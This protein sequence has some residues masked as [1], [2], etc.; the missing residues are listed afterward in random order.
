MTIAI[1]LAGLG[2]I[3]L[4]AHLPALQ[5]NPHVR[6]AGLVDPDPARRAVA[7]ELRVAPVHAELSAV[8]GDPDVRAVVLAT[9]PWVTTELVL[10]VTATGRPVLAEKPVATSVT[11]AQV[12]AG[13]SAERRRL[14]QVGLTYRHDPALELLRER[15]TTGV[16]GDPLLVRAHVYDERRDRADTAHADRIERTLEHGM[17]VLHEGAHVFDW[18]RYLL[19]SAPLLVGDAWSVRTRADLPAANLCGARLVYPQGTVALVEFGWLTDAQP[20]CELSFLG[21]RG[22]ALLDGTSFRVELHTAGGVEQV[23]FQPDRTTRCF[24]RQLERFVELVTGRRSAPEPDLADGIAA[25]ELSERI[26]ELARKE[27]A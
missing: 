21:D 6:I 18:L 26:G 10:A 17:P 24:D 8:L 16:L 5:R 4:H 20:R 25:L 7:E 3:G 11:A 1:A 19:G 27:P 9:P 2:D 12:L 13:L 22:H 14:V 15:I 23:D